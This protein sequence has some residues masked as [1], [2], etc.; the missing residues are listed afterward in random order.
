MVKTDRMQQS[1]KVRLLRKKLRE[2]AGETLIET[3]AAL[4]VT[5]MGLTLLPGAIVAAARLNGAV[6]QQFV[7]DASASGDGTSDGGAN[8]ASETGGGAGSDGTSDAGTSGTTETNGGASGSAGSVVFGGVS[9]PVT[10]VT[11][12]QKQDGGADVTFYSYRLK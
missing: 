5:T 8:G 9:I 6:K 10:V 11:M 1:G 7:S 2:T 12:T 4:L 3:L